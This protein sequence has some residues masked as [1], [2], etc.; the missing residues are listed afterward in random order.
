MGR[1][2]AQGRQEKDVKEGSQEN[3][4]NEWHKGIVRGH[5]V[6]IVACQ[7][8]RIHCRR[9]FVCFNRYLRIYQ[10][11]GRWERGSTVFYPWQG[12]EKKNGLCCNN[13]FKWLQ[14]AVKSISL[15]QAILNET[16]GVCTKGMK[17][18]SQLAKNMISS[19]A[20]LYLATQT[21]PSLLVF[22]KVTE[23]TLE[24]S[25][26]ILVSCWIFWSQCIQYTVS[27]W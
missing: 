12:R 4:D 10:G 27:P 9:D 20:L 19:V 23:R 14:K 15:L 5:A 13:P 22:Q 25:E 7:L 17:T 18:E 8:Q 3:R 2:H 6:S 16:V 11:H 1:S 24:E 21:L 26:Q